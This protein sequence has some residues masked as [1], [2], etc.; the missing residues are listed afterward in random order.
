MSGWNQ[1]A[2]QSVPSLCDMLKSDPIRR[3]IDGSVQWCDDHP[4]Y[5]ALYR[6]QPGGLVGAHSGGLRVNL[7]AVL[8]SPNG[9]L[10]KVGDTERVYQA[11][12][13]IVW[14]DACRHSV[15][16]PMDCLLYTSD[17]ADEEDSVDLGGRRIIKKKKKRK[18][19]KNRIH[20]GKKN[21]IE[22]KNCKR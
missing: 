1:T 20:K 21:E 2:C 16:H 5:A 14:E 4:G 15:E 10:L 22:N 8:R 11:G 7:Q 6:T 3:F 12:E 13:V 9:V 17:A 19:I 18:L